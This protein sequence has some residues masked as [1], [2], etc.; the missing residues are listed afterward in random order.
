M[1][2][3]RVRDSAVGTTFAV[4]GGIEPVSPLEGPIRVGGP[5][6]DVADHV[7]DAV[8]IDALGER[9]GLANRIGK[10]VEVASVQ[11]GHVKRDGRGRPGVGLSRP[12][13]ERSLL[14]RGTRSSAFRRTPH[15]TPRVRKDV[16]RLRGTRA[17][18]L[19]LT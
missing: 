7:V 4:L 8:V 15:A 10:L 1:V 2:V 11:V 19:A 17:A 13:R 12:C 5:L 16:C 6:L 9:T 18:W 3:E 14:R